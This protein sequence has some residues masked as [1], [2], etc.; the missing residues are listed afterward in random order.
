MDARHTLTRWHPADGPCSP[1]VRVSR[2]GE[3][4]YWATRIVRHVHADPS[5]NR[6]TL[7][8]TDFIF[9]HTV[10]VFERGQYGSL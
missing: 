9:N 6:E 7:V 5:R 2:P 4:A 8:S 3:P 10:R 1:V